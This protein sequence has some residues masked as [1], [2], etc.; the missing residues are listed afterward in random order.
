MS[1]VDLVKPRTSSGKTFITTL[2]FYR[3]GHVSMNLS[4][5]YFDSM[6]PQMKHLISNHEQ[7]ILD[8][9]STLYHST[10]ISEQQIVD[11]SWMINCIAN[12]FLHISAELNKPDHKRDLCFYYDQLF[13]S[14]YEKSIF[15]IEFNF[16]SNIANPSLSLRYLNVRVAF[17]KYWQPNFR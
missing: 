7:R 2:F 13:W 4:Y 15:G 3:S 12:D 16:L 14:D 6:V 1:F 17:F 8:G 11:S 5:Q 10:H 9:S